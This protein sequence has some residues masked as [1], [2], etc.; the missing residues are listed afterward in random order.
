[1]ICE[2]LKKISQNSPPSTQ[3]RPNKN[4]L[5]ILLFVLLVFFLLFCYTEFISSCDSF[6]IS[7]TN[8]LRILS[9]SPPQVSHSDT[10]YTHQ[11]RRGATLV[12]V[13]MSVLSL[14]RHERS[15]NEN[16]TPS[17]PL[18][19]VKSHLAWSVVRWVTTCE[20]RV[21][22]VLFCLFCFAACSLFGYSERR[23]AEPGYCS[24]SFVLFFCFLVLCL[25]CLSLLLPLKLLDRECRDD[26]TK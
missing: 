3:I 6:Q 26:E 23:G 14:R 12:A 5:F 9:P 11:H 25:T 4:I 19:E 2:Y 20:A 22:F 13:C 24:F 7:M 10:W 1:V 18:W 15:Y 8:L 21:L 16:Y 17:R